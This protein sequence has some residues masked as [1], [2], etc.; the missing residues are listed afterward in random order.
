MAVGSSSS[1]ARRKL[2]LKRWQGYST[3]W[4][5]PGLRAKG[6]GVSSCSEACTTLSYEFPTRRALLEAVC[7]VIR[8]AQPC[9]HDRFVRRPAKRAELDRNSP[10]LGLAAIWHELSG[11]FDMERM[12]RCLTG[13]L[14]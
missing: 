2:R 6:R 14:R 12:W 11:Q 4:A 5:T 1:C 9:G 10:V 8:A 3:I 7:G 13:E